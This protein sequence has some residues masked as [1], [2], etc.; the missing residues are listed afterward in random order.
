MYNMQR[1]TGY[2]SSLTEMRDRVEECPGLALIIVG[3]FG[4]SHF[5]TEFP[6]TGGGVRLGSR[7]RPII[8]YYP[9]I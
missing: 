8:D 4:I 1:I 3:P 2:P 9:C 5:T 7:D 6:S